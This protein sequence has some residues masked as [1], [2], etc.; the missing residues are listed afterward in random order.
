MDSIQ[1]EINLMKSMGFW[2]NYNSN[3]SGIMD[4]IRNQYF[5]TFQ[6]EILYN[7]FLMNIKLLTVYSAKL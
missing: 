7:L 3:Y 4:K 1:Y 5:N 6:N 2:N